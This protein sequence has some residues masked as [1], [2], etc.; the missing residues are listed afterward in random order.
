MFTPSSRRALGSFHPWLFIKFSSYF[1]SVN[2]SI[3]TFT[4]FEWVWEIPVTK[5][6]ALSNIVC[7]V[8]L[9]IVA[10]HTKL[11]SPY[12]FGYISIRATRLRLGWH[13]P[14]INRYS[15]SSM[16]FEKYQD[17]I[18]DYVLKGQTN[19]DPRFSRT[20]DIALLLYVGI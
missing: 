10:T 15:Y 11:L 1:R 9:N 13:N 8:S 7:C 19:P 20:G 3:I 16:G 14:W 4:Y 5:I 17:W 2:I 18:E 12:F 6:R